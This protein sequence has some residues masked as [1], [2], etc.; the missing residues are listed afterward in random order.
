MVR[1]NCCSINADNHDDDGDG[2][3]GDGDAF[4]DENEGELG[5]K[6]GRG[7]EEGGGRDHY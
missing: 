6:G 3:D 2:D 5:G 7:D 4:R 1:N